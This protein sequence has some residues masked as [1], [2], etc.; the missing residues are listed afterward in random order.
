MDENSCSS[1]PPPLI[2]APVINASSVLTPLG[3]NATFVCTNFQSDLAS[4]II[5]D[6][7]GGTQLV[8]VE[9]D[10]QVE[11][12]RRN[13][14]ESKSAGEIVLDVL[15][16]EM[17][18]NSRVKCRDLQLTPLFSMT[19]NV[20]VI[21][22]SSKH[23]AV[24]YGFTARL[25]CSA[26]PPLSPAVMSTVVNATL[27]VLNWEEPFTWPGHNITHY[28]ITQ[29]VSGEPQ[30]SNT[31]QLSHM[32]LS[33]SGETPTECQNVTFMV[34]AVSDLG[35]SEP[36]VL[37]TGLPKCTPMGSRSRNFKMGGGGSSNFL[38]KGGGV[39]PFFKQFMLE[40]GESLW[41]YQS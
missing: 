22:E 15:A 31:T 25:L 18:N 11:L 30:H 9:D 37:D 28:D 13:I 5:M 14:F 10:D 24:E 34:S 8:V 27:L 35:A 40:I 33:P 12:R 32:Y 7:V 1:P 2:L 17:N 19:F 16:N 39:N 36:D 3:E 4:F 29:H 38:Q 26:G 23:P 41:W 20:T 6:E 21:G